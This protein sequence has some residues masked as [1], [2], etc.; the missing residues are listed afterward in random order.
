MVSGSLQL[1]TYSK[2]KFSLLDEMHNRLALPREIGIKTDTFL[3]Y[4]RFPLSRYPYR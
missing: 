3:L 1:I 4:V 2:A